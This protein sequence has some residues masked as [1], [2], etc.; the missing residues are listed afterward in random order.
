MSPGGHEWNAAAADPVAAFLHAERVHLGLP[1]GEAE[2]EREKY[3]R[4]SAEGGFPR[5]A[6]ELGA[7]DWSEELPILSAASQLPRSP[8]VAEVYAGGVRAGELR[9]A[10]LG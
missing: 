6:N 2:R 8:V 9:E 5:A 1:P 4:I 3:F 7:G 10:E